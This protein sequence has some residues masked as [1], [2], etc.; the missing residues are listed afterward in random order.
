MK[1]KIT[2]ILTL[3][4]GILN[5]QQ[6]EDFAGI[7]NAPF[8]DIQ[9]SQQ[10]MVVLDNGHVVVAYIGTDFVDQVKVFEWDGQT[11]LQYAE[12]NQGLYS[13]ITDLNII[14]QG[15]LAYVGF[16]SQTNDSYRVFKW[17]PAGGLWIDLDGGTLDAAMSSALFTTSTVKLSISDQTDDIVLSYIQQFSG[18]RPNVFKLVSGNWDTGFGNNLFNI[19]DA[20]TP[21]PLDAY[22]QKTFY[23]GN[24]AYYLSVNS[25]GSGGG[26]KANGNPE[27]RMYKGDNGALW[28]SVK[29]VNPAG[30]I[31]IQ[32]NPGY[33][34]MTGMGNG[35][36][37]RI[38]Y[39][40]SAELN[41]QIK[42]D[43][44][45]S[46]FEYDQ[47]PTYDL[48]VGIGALELDMAIDNNTFIYCAIA[49]DNNGGGAYFNK[50]ISYDNTAWNQIG[51]DF[52]NLAISNLDVEVFKASGKTYVLYKEDNGVGT[53]LVKLKVF[54]QTPIAGSYTEN[55]ICQDA[56][57]QDIIS[58]INYQDYDNDSV[59]VVN[60][61][62][63]NQTLIPNANLTSTRISTYDYTLPDNHFKITAT[64]S[65]GN[66]G[67]A[68]ISFVVSDGLIND[69][70]LFS[71]T[72][73]SSPT[74]VANSTG[75]TACSGDNFT[76]WG[77]G[78]DT[79]TWDNGVTD[80]TPF[81]ITTGGTYTVT[82]TDING[83]S[84]TASTTVT[85]NPLPTFTVNTN[86][87][88]CNGNI[89]GIINLVTGVNSTTFIV[90][91][92][93]N[94]SPLQQTLTSSAVG[95]TVQLNGLQAGNYDNFQITNQITACVSSIDPNTYTITEPTVLTSNNPGDQTVCEGD[96]V[97]LFG[98]ASG[99]T[100]SYSYAWD[101][102]VTDG[103]PFTPS[104]G[105]IIYNLV[106]TDNNGCTVN[107]QV[108]VT[109]NPVPVVSSSTSTNPTTCGGSDGEIILYG[110]GIST[111]YNVDYDKDGI[112][113]STL[114]ITSNGSGDL[115]I[116][117]LSM[118]T[119]DN[120]TIIETA[121]G[122][123]GSYANSFDLTDPTPPT[124]IAGNDQTIC[125]GTSV[126][127]TA[128]NPN[129]AAITWD[130]GVTDGV[131]F[132]PG[133]GVTTYTVTADL[134]GCT[135]TDQVTVSVN[136]LPS[137]NAGTDQTICE[138]NQITLTATN[139]NGATINWDNGV[140]D[141]VAFAPMVGITTYTVTADLSGCISTDQVVITTNPTPLLSTPTSTNPT[142][143]GG[144]D[145]QIVFP[146]L[147]AATNFTVD[148]DKNS[149]AQTQ[150]SLTTDGTGNLTINNLSSASY[151]N[152]SVTNTYGCSGLY[153]TPIVLSDPG[154]PTVNP[155]SE[156]T[157]CPGDDFLTTTFTGTAGA[158]F[159]WSN[160]NTS[161]GLGASG[162]G[163]IATFTA[164]NTSSSAQ[165]ANITVTPTQGGCT[166]TS[167]S[168]TL[169][170]N[171][172]DD[173]SF[174]YSANSYCLNESNPIP[175]ITLGGGVFTNTVVSGGPF[176]VNNS[177]GEINLTASSSGTVDIT[178][179]T[180]GTCPN[181]SVMT[182]TLND[183]PVLSSPTPTSICLNSGLLDLNGS[184]T[185]IGGTY[186]GNYI[187]NNA[188][189][190]LNSG[191]GS[192]F[193]YNY[194]Y[195]DLNGC[196][197]TTSSTIE[198]L[199]IP[200]IGLN[201]T[202]TSCGNSD[203]VVISNV[204]G[205]LSPYTYYWSNG[206]TGP[207]IT[208]LSANTYY[209]NITDANNCYVMGVATIQS[210][211][212]TLSGNVTDN[213]CSGLNNGAIDL[214][215]TG[216]TGPYTYYWS[217]G[218][219]TEDI[220]NLIAG[221]YEVFVTDANGCT[222]T[223]SFNVGEPTALTSTINSTNTSVCGANDGSLT[224]TVFGGTAPYTFDW[225]NS[226]NSSIGTSNSV[227][228][229]G[230]G[231][232]NLSVIDNNGC[233]LSTNGEVS[234]NGA[235]N[236]VL[237][238]KSPAS[239]ANDG[240]IDI[241]ISATNA[242]QSTIWSNSQTTEDITNLSPGYYTVTVTDVN[243]C[244]SNFGTEVEPV[245]PNPI[246][247]CIVTVDTSTNTN[248]IVWNKPVSTDIEYFIIY[249]ESSVAGEFL[250]VDTIPYNDLS[251]FTD[252]VAYPQLRSWRYKISVV[253]TCG[254]ESIKSDAHKTI[255]ITISQ[256]LSGTY[257]VAWDNYE[258]FFFSTF[259]LYRFTDQNGWELIQSLPATN[260]SFTD[261]PPSTNGLDYIISI[262]P[263]N[264]CTA[265]KAIDHN[266]SRS[267]NTNSITSPPGSNGTDG[268]TE[269]YLA[270]LVD[271]FPNPSNGEFNI[272]LNIDIDQNY[273][274]NIYDI[275]GSIVKSMSI[276]TALFT[277]NLNDYE[278]GMYIL[279]IKSDENIVRKQLI[280]R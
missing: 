274:V 59:Y 242:I 34:A 150:L 87:I 179:T 86:N 92:N 239:C 42:F 35:D 81:A 67:T 202:N 116:S 61:F 101:N 163:D 245:Y 95:G 88:T 212:I 105:A 112:A 91:Y 159:N 234:D 266:A 206:T 258:G 55:M 115:T 100:S 235:P 225:T 153:S 199:D 76:F 247:I 151:S 69:T 63:D 77:S 252:P 155:V 265:S 160:D 75:T 85:V 183:V 251:E 21:T 124:V 132:T 109:V 156:Q 174:D 191:V 43:A 193:N 60:I 231:I 125:D 275:K 195:T 216:T 93:F 246:E 198:V 71:I 53:Y 122:C 139:P 256:G 47:I 36:F 13:N 215:V 210:S 194:S 221:E 30:S 66:S 1:L 230:D 277:V 72:V 167:T 98:S 188:F 138:S 11:W 2:F 255:H 228:G 123:V 25:D 38:G 168:F 219:T 118:A 31:Y 129:G 97:T 243:G 203:G 169:I 107:D 73:N 211:T 110:L 273:I 20:N 184:V 249:R 135:S 54:N 39:T 207:E 175:T 250:P 28:D 32:D 37:P 27:L 16:G 238:Q 222:S 182:I 102:G 51:G 113:Q 244:S 154:S 78:A 148:Y 204:T 14:N 17:D 68:N 84:N 136:V 65:A 263:P 144:T 141:G 272:D 220:A 267:N 260:F 209:L 164:I 253:N 96:Q 172:L 259:D 64:P 119:Y 280:K 208:N 15:N 131:P 40:W 133:V 180:I 177:S 149:V 74:V 176:T 147:D 229:I 23:N 121:N 214:T 197:A 26:A 94:S 237:E 29:Y 5:A 114:S 205:G 201:I 232:Y 18:G 140:I 143:C 217:N 173:A 52:S 41:Q 189:D 44:V 99:G 57:T 165:M 117:G 104:V 186:S 264:T 22:E 236:I 111:N 4:V 137:V 50:V 178:Y 89:D 187:G 241:T 128:T 271:V 226:S 227:T 9:T 146:L 24:H 170:V 270:S 224:A 126:T 171:P 12:P 45:N 19:F 162:T 200:T 3:F 48:G 262:T 106:I 268:I 192:A 70:L 10:D 46:L 257:N 130:N 83:C 49:S 196:T 8:K 80:N 157:V 261:T 134:T 145:G 278:G 223:I 161:I 62:S 181:S 185:P 142:T 166:G 120:F 240:A 7:T 127:L 56:G 254:I 218:E 90:D 58:D 6:W 103:V 269:S 279:E 108:T 190:P 158:T 33:F 213:L 248:K 152:F 79:Y 82:G 233:T 276:N